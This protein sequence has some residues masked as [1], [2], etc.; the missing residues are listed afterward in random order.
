MNLD[1]GIPNLW[2]GLDP[3]PRP[4]LSIGDPHDLDRKARDVSRVRRT[5]T[6]GLGSYDLNFVSV[7][8]ATVL[9]AAFSF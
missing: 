4:G 9:I 2:T 7:R 3:R 6:V 5:R 1:H 8:M